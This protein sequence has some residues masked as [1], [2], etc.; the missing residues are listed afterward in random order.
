MNGGMIFTVRVGGDFS[1]QSKHPQ[2]FVCTKQAITLA[3]K[4]WSHSWLCSCTMFSE[5]RVSSCSQS[6]S[7]STR[8]LTGSKGAAWSCFVAKAGQETAAVWLLLCKQ[9]TLVYQVHNT[10][11]CHR[12]YEYHYAAVPASASLV[13]YE[14]FTTLTLSTRRPI[15][16]SKY[17]RMHTHI[18]CARGD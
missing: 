13:Y 14:V 15:E 4:W 2:A 8:V 17:M 7:N 12:D 18:Y 1:F 10:Q 6:R 3:A 11:G 16:L 9:L 5:E